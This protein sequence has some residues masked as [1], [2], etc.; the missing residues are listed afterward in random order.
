MKKLT[1]LSLLILR[2]GV[3]FCQNSSGTTEESMR[4]LI[5]DKNTAYNR[6][7]WG[8]MKQFHTMRCFQKMRSTMRAEKQ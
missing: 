6:Q 3:A 2:W 8:S 7:D 5:N 4:K 1:I